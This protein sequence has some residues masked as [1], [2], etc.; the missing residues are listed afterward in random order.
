MSSVTDSPL[1]ELTEWPNDFGNWGRWDNERGTL[2]L[3]TSEKVLQ[4]TRTVSDGRV[5][6]CAAPLSPEFYP[7][8]LRMTHNFDEQGYR[9]EMLSADVFDETLGKYAAQDKFTLSIH[10]LE[11][12]HLDA[13]QPRR[14]LRTGV[15][16]CRLR[17]DGDN[18]GEGEAVRRHPA[19]WHRDARDP[20]RRPA[21]PRRRVPRAR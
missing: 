2:N 8:T 20:R 19:P 3:I 13:L 5:F 15:Q 1:S 10:S 9:H 16:R 14:P 21:H 7:E 11:N 17:R 12:T 18:G 4:A 6:A